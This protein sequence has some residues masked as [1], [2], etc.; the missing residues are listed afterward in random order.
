SAH[1]L[2]ALLN[3]IISLTPTISSIEDRLNALQDAGQTL[4]ANW[5]QV[6]A[7]ISECVEAGTLLE[8]GKLQTLHNAIDTITPDIKS[9]TEWETLLLASLATRLHEMINTYAKSMQMRADLD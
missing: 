4:P 2:R 6:L 7:Q 1:L 8:P 9:D 5:Q 3:R